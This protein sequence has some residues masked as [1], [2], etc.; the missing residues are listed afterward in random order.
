MIT[1]LTVPGGMGGRE[2]CAALRRLEPEPVVVASSGY[3]ND[4]LLAEHDRFGF[5]GVL[6]KPYSL[7]QLDKVVRSNLSR[8]PVAVG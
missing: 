7:Q 8:S 1:D 3:S 2:L 6:V 5:S 4:P